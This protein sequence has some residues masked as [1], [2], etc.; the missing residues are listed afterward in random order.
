MTVRVLHLIDTLSAG[1]AER[2]AVNLANGLAQRGMVCSL[3]ATRRE[4]PLKKE[5]SPEVR[6][7]YLNRQARFDIA[8]I[9]R[10]SRFVKEN[11]IQIIHAHSSSIFL[12]ALFKL[13]HPQTR[14]IWHDHYGGLSVA[15]RSAFL[16]RPVIQ[17]VDGVIAVNHELAEWSAN[18]LGV[19]RS[20]IRYIPNFVMDTRKG[21]MGDLPGS[22]GFRIICV[23]NLRP[24]KDHLTLIQ[25]MKTVIAQEPRAHLILVGS[26]KDR[27]T[28]Q[29]ILKEISLL[30]LESSITWLGSREDVND[31]LVA[32][33]IGVLSSA[34]EGLPLVLLEYGAAGL[35]VVST[36][37]GD[38]AEVLDFGNA[39]VLVP[40]GSSQALAEGLI[41]LLEDPTLRDTLGSRLKNRVSQKFSPTAALDQVEE[42]Y[43][44]V[45]MEE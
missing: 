13:L 2:M 30:G 16:Y 31:I 38:C 12:A 35:P 23:A 18:Q 43:K 44:T 21:L 8:A 34:S 36:D 1:G 15:K 29:K 14:V 41:R 37:V 9:A 5:L 42:F 19:P 33:D 40:P 6:F 24:Q 22:K 39:G 28:S 27:E 4:G 45:L 25:A 20:R 32:C 7:F 11:S 3:C 17:N 26:D 10:L